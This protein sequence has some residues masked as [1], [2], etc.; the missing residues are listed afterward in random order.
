MIRKEKKIN[1]DHLAPRA[2]RK[3]RAKGKMKKKKQ[4][5]KIEI[6]EARERAGELARAIRDFLKGVSAI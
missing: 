4:E 6:R 5:K 3:V 1:G 2:R